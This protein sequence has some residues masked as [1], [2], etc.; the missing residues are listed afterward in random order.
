MK[1]PSTE[2]TTARDA[3]PEEQKKPRTRGNVSRPA[4][5]NAPDFAKHT[6]PEAP[7]KPPVRKLRSVHRIPVTA[8]PSDEELDEV[9][10]EDLSD[11]SMTE[12]IPMEVPEDPATVAP[13]SS[14]PFSRARRG[15]TVDTGSEGLYE[16]VRK[17]TGFSEDDI[18]MIFE[19]GY[20]SELGRAIGYETLKKLKND[21]RRRLARE[22]K[23]HYLNSFG[24]RGS[25][26][27]N[28]QTADGVLATYLHDRK[29]LLL[30]TLMTALFTVLLFFL[31][32]PE[33]PA[34]VLPLIAEA[35]HFLF[36]LLSLLALLGASV[37]SFHEIKAGF[38]SYFHLKPT[39]Y[40]AVAVLLPLTVIYDILSFF[41]TAQMMRVDLITCGALLVLSLCDILRLSS[42]MHTFELLAT[43]GEK[44]VL[45]PTMPRKKKL[46]Q[47]KKLVK[48]INDD[49]D[50][51]FY[52]VHRAVEVT[53]F[54]RRFN[55]FSAMHR[56]F[57][58]LLGIA[59]A[60]GLACGFAVL[61]VTGDLSLA[62]SALMTA[63]I[64]AAPI[65]AIFTSF[66][67]LCRANR[68]LSRYRC[69]LVGEEAV[70]EYAHSKTV[71]FSDA[72]LC[73][74]EKCAEIAVRESE[75]FREDLR[76]AGALFGKIGGS[77]SSISRST[78]TRA[79][80]DAQVAFVR[81]ADNGVEA[82]VDNRNHMIA[83]SAEFLKKSGIRVSKET[84]DRALRRASNVGMMYVAIN[85]VLKL[86]YEMEY[87]FRPAF[88]TMAAELAEIDTAVAI[89]SYDP[90]LNESFLQSAREGGI[91]IRVIKPGRFESDSVS[92]TSD[93]GAVAL[94]ESMD[95]LYPLYAAKGVDL[96][97]KFGF[98]LQLWISL[99]SAVAVTV[100]SLLGG[101]GII[102]WLTPSLLGAYHLCIIAIT[103]LASAAY[104]NRFTLRIRREPEDDTTA[105]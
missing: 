67:P 78:V 28:R 102:E 25:E 92:Q 105:Q 97:H 23:T 19:L 63:L 18:A 49:I 15:M 38:V 74:A 90:N 8:L 53:G 103:A 6:T 44:T 89:Q 104:I 16:F 14:S 71:I 46:R 12:E 73:S 66:Y 43:V 54:F 35:P 85:G 34:S 3:A 94:D 26:D 93:T 98:F 56:P 22:N 30:R 99:G 87:T 60:L 62:L 40:S 79:G 32:Q 1:Q 70:E 52:R 33:I 48:I 57:H 39:P 96:S 31:G 55:D 27:V 100:L 75:D 37:F 45:E 47:G 4:P 41:T 42:E 77:L 51:S 10:D 81:I 76:L 59:P 83:G 86:S 7:K 88:E 11:D 9:L 72:D 84:T 36:P 101:T 82:V 64:A 91:P 5:G 13:P 20:E 68:L 95:I 2:H 17:K 69:A 65:S 61:L 24:Y 50:E 80:S 58:I 29:S 21:H